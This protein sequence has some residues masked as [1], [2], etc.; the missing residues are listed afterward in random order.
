MLSFHMMCHSKDVGVDKSRRT[1]LPKYCRLDLPDIS[2]GQVKSTCYQKPVLPVLLPKVG[3][4]TKTS[5]PKI[6]L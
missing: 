2:K 1:D 5:T 6:E 4:P 3:Y